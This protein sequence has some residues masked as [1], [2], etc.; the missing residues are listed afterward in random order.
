MV[1]RAPV[2]RACRV[3][4]REALGSV[5]DIARRLSGPRTAIV[6]PPYLCS[7]DDR[8]VWM[9]NVATGNRGACFDITLIELAEAAPEIPDWEFARCNVIVVRKAGSLTHEEASMRPRRLL[10]SMRRYF[11]IILTSESE[12]EHARLVEAMW[13]G[14]ES[15]ALRTAVESARTGGE[16]R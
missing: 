6:S 5:A 10:Q 3:T 4:T 9:L 15:T 1:E 12:I 16:R 8:G 7:G 13:P 14:T 2:C 11:P